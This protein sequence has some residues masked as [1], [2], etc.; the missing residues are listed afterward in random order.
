[1]S[2]IVTY[3]ARL[4]TSL[5][6]MDL[7]ESVVAL[8]CC[9]VALSYAI[10]TSLIALTTDVC[11]RVVCLAMVFNAEIIL[12]VADG[13]AGSSVILNADNIIIATCSEGDIATYGTP[14]LSANQS[15]ISIP[16]CVSYALRQV[17]IAS[18]DFCNEGVVL[19]AFDSSY[20]PK[21]NNRP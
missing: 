7:V 13:D 8:P 11:K 9:R 2:L 20:A 4:S 15:G 14:L 1:M 17:T 16:P 21:R 18:I 5:H 10:W 3:I 12:C 6:R 19:V